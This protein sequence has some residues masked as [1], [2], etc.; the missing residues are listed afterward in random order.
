MFTHQ[1][2]DKREIENL[3]QMA[4]KVILRNKFLHGYHRQ[5]GKGPL[6]ETHHDRHSSL[7]PIT[8]CFPSLV[9]F[10]LPISYI[11]SLFLVF[12]CISLKRKSQD[13]NFEKGILQVSRTLTRIPTRM[14]GRGYMEAEPKTQR[15]RRSIVV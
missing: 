6:F 13:I 10:H 3:V 15:S 5:W 1:I 8:P 4:I 12:T 14:E 11:L 9:N 2:V 7:Y